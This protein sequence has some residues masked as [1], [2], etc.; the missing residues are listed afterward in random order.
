MKKL[1]YFTICISFIS[2][3]VIATEVDSL[4]AKSVVTNFLLKYTVENPDQFT[5]IEPYVCYIESFNKDALFYIVNFQESTH[6]IISADD[7]VLPILGYSKKSDFDRIGL[8]NGMYFYF[9]MING[10]AVDSKRVIIN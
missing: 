8:S 10:K 7:N 5:K 2:N 1:L 9:L 4:T 6:A 3:L